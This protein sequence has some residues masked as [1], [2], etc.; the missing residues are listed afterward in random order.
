MALLT[1]LMGLGSVSGKSPSYLGA[2]A[3]F[4]ATRGFGVKI[5]LNEVKAPHA[6]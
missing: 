4:G 3:E 6:N 1:T 5:E 2:R